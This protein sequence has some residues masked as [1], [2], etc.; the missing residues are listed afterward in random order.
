MA[1]VQYF[2]KQH[3]STSSL[4]PAVQGSVIIIFTT[5]KPF[6]NSV[7]IPSY[8][9]QFNKGYWENIQLF[10]TSLSASCARDRKDK[11]TPIIVILFKTLSTAEEER[12]QQ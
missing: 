5:C 6:Q 9:I 4:E 10:L 12:E 3:S 1:L 2:S 7:W 8:S 11:M